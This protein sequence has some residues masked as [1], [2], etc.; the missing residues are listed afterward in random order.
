[1]R[2][3]RPTLRSSFSCW[4]T[5]WRCA[6]SGTV[7]APWRCAITTPGS[8]CLQ[9]RA[10]RRCPAP[11]RD[12][13]LRRLALPRSHEDAGDIATAS[14]GSR[15]GADHREDRAFREATTTRRTARSPSRCS[16]ACSGRRQPKQRDIRTLDVSRIRRARQ[17]ARALHE[18][19][20]L[21][22]VADLLERPRFSGER[23]DLERRCAHVRDAWPRLAKCLDRLG[24]AVSLRKRLC[25][26]K[27]GLDLG[28][29]L[30]GDA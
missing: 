7:R 23:A 3:S 26:R 5:L 15:P 25:P 6:S 22:N 28:A 14:E 24:V 17:S 20:R 10:D 11:A 2:S 29:L 8:S 1:M 12:R 4:K 19:D 13:A 18:S 16:R 27:Q 9:W 30:S 21:L